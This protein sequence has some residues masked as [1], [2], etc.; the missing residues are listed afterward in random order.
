MHRNW[1]RRSFIE[2]VL[3]FASS[4]PKRRCQKY[5]EGLS[6]IKNR[7]VS[8]KLLSLYDAVDRPLNLILARMELKGVKVDTAYLSSLSNQFKA[9]I[10]E[11]ENDIYSESGEEFN[12]ASPK[13][14]GEVLFVKMGL[15]GG[16]KT[17]VELLERELMCWRI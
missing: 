12:I 15:A 3:E 9:K 4:G 10:R 6:I 11:L 5:I 7:L 1:K 2:G 17:K 14:L 8:D 13:Q 16:K